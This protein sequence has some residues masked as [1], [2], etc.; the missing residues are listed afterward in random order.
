MSEKEKISFINGMFELFLSR[1]VTP[2]VKLRLCLYGLPALDFDVFC[3]KVTGSPE[4]KGY[5]KQKEKLARDAQE[6]LGIENIEDLKI[7]DV[8]GLIELMNAESK[9]ELE[10]LDIDLNFINTYK[11]PKID[12][13]SN[14]YGVLKPFINFKQG[15]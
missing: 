12:L 3:E 14:D 7:T 8:K 5:C 15:V 4:F 10:K 13:N 6:E 1:E 2:I 11:D 9:L